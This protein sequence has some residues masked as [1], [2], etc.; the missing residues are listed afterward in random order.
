MWNNTDCSITVL[1]TPCH[2]LYVVS[3]GWCY[4]SRKWGAVFVCQDMPFFAKFASARGIV[5]LGHRSPPSLNATLSVCGHQAI[6]MS[7]WC[8]LCRHMVPMLWPVFFW[9][10]LAEPILETVHGVWNR[11]HSSGRHFSGSPV[12][13]I[14]MM[15]PVT[16]LKGTVGRGRPTALPSFSF[17]KMVLV[18]SPTLCGDFVMVCLCADCVQMPQFNEMD[19]NN[20]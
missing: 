13:R 1:S 8:P 9:K 18:S 7:D 4:D 5:Y 10:C 20:L 3:A 2:R 11:N 15:P 12:L 14:C 17:G 19:G 6:A 16:F